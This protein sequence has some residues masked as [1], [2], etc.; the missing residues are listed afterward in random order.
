[1]KNTRDRC[2]LRFKQFRRNLKA[3]KLL[4]ILTISLGVEL[5]SQTGCPQNV[6]AYIEETI[7]GNSDADHDTFFLV[8]LLIY[9]QLC[10]SCCFRQNTQT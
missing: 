6:I 10:C 9:R 7:R 4:S 3:I 5:L 8:I 1:M 2:C